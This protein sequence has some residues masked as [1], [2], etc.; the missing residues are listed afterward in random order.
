[1]S[2][3][4]TLGLFLACILLALSAGLSL[5]AETARPRLLTLA[6]FAFHGAGAVVFW[7]LM[8]LFSAFL[9]NDFSIRYVVGLSSTNLKR[10]R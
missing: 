1:M 6:S 10:R 7:C 9:L 4:G 5:L 8:L 3:P 2:T